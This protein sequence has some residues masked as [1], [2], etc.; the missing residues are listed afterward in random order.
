[1]AIFPRYGAAQFALAEAYRKLNDPVR[2]EAA[3]RDYERDKTVLPP[4]NDP[5][6][7]ALR[8]L[9]VSPTGLLG[10]AAELERDG[11]LQESL[12]LLNRAIAADPRLVDAYSN[13]ISIY[14]RLG[15][16]QEAERAYAQSIRLDA[17][18]PEAYYNFGV[19]C[20]E[21]NRFP[22]AKAAFEKVVRL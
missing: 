17:N 12:E 1:L 3:M 8:A 6:M 13:A 4:A 20:F 11:R 22:E 10:V 9:N 14:G 18:Q 7:A 15:R 5:E 2:A 19:F 21:R 16:D